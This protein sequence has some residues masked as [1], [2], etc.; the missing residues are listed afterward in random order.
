MRCGDASFFVS[1]GS[2][3]LSYP[4]PTPFDPYPPPNL[5]PN[6]SM[7]FFFFNDPLNYI[8]VACRRMAEELLTGE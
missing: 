8:R 6:V 3:S 5:I 4:P 1:F 2:V 7:S